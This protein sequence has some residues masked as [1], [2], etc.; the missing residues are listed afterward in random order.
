MRDCPACHGELP[1][2][3]RF[4]PHCGEKVFEETLTCPECGAENAVDS[5]FCFICGKA[6]FSE[7]EKAGPEPHSTPEPEPQP[8]PDLNDLF[9]APPLEEIETDISEKFT[10][11]LRHRI[12]E[13]HD[14][15]QL[16]T[17]LLHFARSGFKQTFDF[18]IRQLAEQVLKF[19]ETGQTHREKRLLNDAFEEALDYFIIHYCKNINTIPLP[20]AILKY[21]TIRRDKVDLGKMIMDYLDF[22]NEPEK[23][24]TDFITMPVQKLKNAGQTFLFPQKAERI[25]F[26]CDQSLL[27]SC[28]EGFAMTEKAIYWKA[29]FE[30]AQRVAYDA[31]DVVRREKEW[32]TINGLF[33]NVN[34]SLNLKLMKLLKRIKR[35][36]NDDA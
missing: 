9:E 28:K 4:C 3:A 25:F 6:F 2:N 21:Q 20:D 19:R 36:M 16:E 26:I 31:L 29:H 17:Y 8:G 33:F 15:A 14:T 18:R 12:E 24:F 32:I 30:P 7:K 23:V 11:A 35:L 13:E 1:E 27:G 5:R 34:P 10:L 22:E